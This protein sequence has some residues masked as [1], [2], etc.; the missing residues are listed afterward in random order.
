METM[1][2]MQDG[3][4][5]EPHD[6]CLAK[7]YVV[8][9]VSDTGCGM[10]EE[11]LSHIFE[12]FFTTKEM[13]KGTGLG[14]ATV[15]G[16]VKQNQ[17]FIDIESNPGQGTTFRIHFPAY[18]R[19]LTETAVPETPSECLIGAGTVLIVEDEQAILQVSKLILEEFGYTVLSATTPGEAIQVF[20]AYTGSI[21][22]LITDVIL[23]EM[24]GKILAERLR[25]HKPD[26]RCIYMSGY[27][28]DII[29]NQGILDEGIYFIQKPFTFRELIKRV[30][31]VIAGE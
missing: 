14:L 29:A 19:D 26:L 6:G 4:F 9:S 10:D 30:R 7:E 5:C 3:G 24:N 8:F 20:E 28:S 31:D 13:G 11:T 27:T 25:S 15:Y 12:P 1:N 2:V 23:P 22:V 17:G 18:K 16:I 21:D